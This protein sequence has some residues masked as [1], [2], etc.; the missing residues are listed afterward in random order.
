MYIV[1]TTVHEYASIKHKINK[2]IQNTRNRSKKHR[3]LEER[4][5]V[6]IYSFR[7]T[8]YVTFFMQS[9]L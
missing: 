6:K 9:F 4:G 5:P 8:Y 2:I 7:H 1:C 3:K